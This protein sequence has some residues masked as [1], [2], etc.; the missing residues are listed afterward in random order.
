MFASW[1]SITKSKAPSA[2]CLSK[3]HSIMFFFFLM[4]VDGVMYPLIVHNKI[5]NTI[6]IIQHRN[7]LS[8]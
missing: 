7:N 3:L 4:Q 1:K 2:G 5:C 8:A 6:I